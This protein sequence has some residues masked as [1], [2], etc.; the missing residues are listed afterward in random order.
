MGDPQSQ[1][2]SN[3]SPASSNKQRGSNYRWVI[4]VLAWVIIVVNYM[5]RT[6]IAYAAASIKNEFHINDAQL[7]G[8]LS[9]FGIGYAVMTL[10]GGIFVDLWGAR[11]VW[12]GAAIAWSAMT[13]A[14]AIA[15]GYWPMF[16]VRT[17][18][19]ITEGPCFPALTRVV[20]DWVPVSERG[21]S[22][23]FGLTA[24]PLASVIGAPTITA[25]I[26]TFGWKAMFCL[27]ACLGIGWAFIWYAA[28]R[29]YPENS[30]HVSPEELA[31]IRGGD[32][33]LAG[34]S[35]EQIREHHL[36]TGKTTWAFMLFNPA[37]MANNW[38]FFSFGYLLFFAISWLPEYMRKTYNLSLHDIGLML[39]IPWLSAA[40]MLSAAG[41]LS[42]LLWRKTGSIRM[43]RSHLIWVCQL[44]SA[45]CLIAVTCV[46][47]LTSGIIFLSLGL[48]FGLCPNASFYALNSDLAGDRAGTSLGLMDCFAAS[49]AVLAPFLTGQLVYATGNFNS[50]IWLMVAFSLSSV[51][52]IILFQ[53]P[54]REIKKATH[55]EHLAALAT[56]TVESL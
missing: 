27:L 34:R 46:H 36:T 39:I 16:L 54:D 6:A 33:R 52:A 9:A 26:A 28:Y 38:A 29:D 13:A 41:W 11:K 40:I 4:M 8:I 53:H 48:A 22:T 10:G 37:L 31:T 18:L 15:A 30:P 12:S 20:T 1:E 45:L 24:V 56:G 32:V 47:S 14:M 49:A 51:V 55:S 2:Q 7:G 5:D 25:L 3:R 50:A 23:A 44:L 35:D 42:D 43:A 17:M 21:R 19:G